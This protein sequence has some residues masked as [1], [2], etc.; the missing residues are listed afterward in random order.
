QPACDRA[1][2][3]HARCPRIVADQDATVSPRPPAGCRTEAGGEI[4]VDDWTS[5]GAAHAVGSE[6]LALHEWAKNSRVAAIFSRTAPP[7]SRARAGAIPPAMVVVRPVI[8]RPVA[9]FRTIV[10]TRPRGPRPAR[11]DS[12]NS[13]L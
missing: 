7:S 11:T 6:V 1:A 2:Q 5:I 13:R 3:G 8:H 9:P 4:L 12:T 10:S